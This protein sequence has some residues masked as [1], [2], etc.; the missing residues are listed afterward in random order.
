MTKPIDNIEDFVARAAAAKAKMPAD[1]LTRERLIAAMNE[2]YCWLDDE[3]TIFDLQYFVARKREQVDADMGHL[4]ATEIID[5]RKKTITAL[6]AW[7]TSPHRLRYAGRKFMPGQEQIA[8]EF[9][10][11]HLGGTYVNLWRGWGCPPAKGDVQP[12]LN[13]IARLCRL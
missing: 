9:K 10:G 11:K 5:E 2:K 13:L 3:K 12:L 6:Q 1:S 8:T 7:L 4:F